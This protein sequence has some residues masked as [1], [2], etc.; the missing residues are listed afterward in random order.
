MS[1]HTHPRIDAFLDGELAGDEAVRAQEHVSRCLVC[2][3]SV[4]AARAL[5]SA[6]A[7]SMPAV[8]A[9][10][11][12]ATRER[13]LGRRVPEAPLWWLALPNPWRAGLAALLLL[14]AVAGVRLGESV[15][16]DRPNAT[17]LAAALGAPATDVML[18]SSGAGVGR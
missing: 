14:A 3:R 7:E 1:D 2:Q 6:L 9:G 5:D 8:P 12:R 4:A 15:A 11:A 10:F 17:E 18:A 16:A 13:A